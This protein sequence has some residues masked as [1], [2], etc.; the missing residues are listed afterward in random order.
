MGVVVLA[1][2]LHDP[3]NR[4]NEVVIKYGPLIR[5]LFPT[6]CVSVTPLTSPSIIETLENLDFH[7]SRGSNNVCDTYMQAF[8]QALHHNPDL[9]FY[10]DFDRLLHWA[11]T[12]PDE[13]TKTVNADVDHDF[14]LVGR[15]ARAFTTHPKTQ[16][17]T[18][19]IANQIAS[20]ASGFPRTRDIISACWRLE[21]RLVGQLLHLPIDNTYGFYCEWP[22]VAWRQARNPRYL[23]VE[24]LEWE[25]PDRYSQE[26]KDKGYTRWFHEFQTPDEWERRVAILR[27]AIHS[28]SKYR[29]TRALSEPVDR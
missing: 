21:P 29:R 10:C 22:I 11:R 27:D 12:Y 13:L 1:S 17:M 15:T 19:A 26:I 4:L 25:T 14:L 16:I 8:Q 7:P 3:E 23:E 20:K 18:E 24:G 2:T 28:I 9:V 5:Q 6:S